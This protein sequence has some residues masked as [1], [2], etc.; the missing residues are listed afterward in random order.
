M[1]GSAQRSAIFRT[2]AQ[3]VHGLIRTPLSTSRPA[4]APRQPCRGFITLAAIG[5]SVYGLFNRERSVM[6]VIGGA[7]LT[8]SSAVGALYS[9]VE[10]GS[11]LW[12]GIY[13]AGCILG[14]SAAIRQGRMDKG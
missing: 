5:L 2:E 11:I 10:I 14:V 9:Y 3:G 13:L 6:C 7:L 8:V 12:A 4:Y 1:A